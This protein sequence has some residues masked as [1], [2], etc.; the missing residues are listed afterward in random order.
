[1]GNLTLALVKMSNSPGSGRPPILGLN[2][3]TCITSRI[4]YVLALNMSEMSFL[5][6]ATLVPKTIAF[7]L[8]LFSFLMT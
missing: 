4:L 1:M 5:N 6:S 7:T 3:D 2:I 8:N